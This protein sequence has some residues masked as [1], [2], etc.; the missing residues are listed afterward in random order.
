MHKPGVRLHLE[1]LVIAKTIGDEDAIA[2]MLEASA[3]HAFFNGDYQKARGYFLESREHYRNVGNSTS[4]LRQLRHLA[5][6]YYFLGDYRQADQCLDEASEEFR[7]IGHDTMVL[8]CLDI[9]AHLYLSQGLFVQVFQCIEAIQIISSRGKHQFHD[10]KN[11]YFHAVI[12]RLQGHFNPAEEYTQNF[13][14]SSRELGQLEL[15]TTGLYEQGKLAV[16][17]GATDHAKRCFLEGMQLSSEYLF[18]FGHAFHYTGLT[19]LAAQLEDNEKAA[20]LFGAADQTFSGLVHV[21]PLGDRIQYQADLNCVR[22]SLG[23]SRF[24]ELYQEG[25]LMTKEQVVGLM[26]EEDE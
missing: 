19:G 24:E 10:A 13:M 15:V 12:A 16:Q 21:L 22:G 20:R 2:V 17:D 14:D 7:E 3:H 11:L 23:E 18:C 9:K 26:M 1:G 8:E 25:R 4:V 5:Y 6:I